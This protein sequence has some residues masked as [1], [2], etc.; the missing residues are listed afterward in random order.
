VGGTTGPALAIKRA[1]DPPDP[2]D[3]RRVL[4]DR[5]WPRGVARDRLQLDEWLKE[6]APSTA[7]RRWFGHD[8]AK[9]REFRRRYFVELDG[10]PEV[11]AALRAEMRQGPVTLVYSARD[12]EHNQALALRDYLLDGARADEPA[13]YASPP[14]FLHELDPAWTGLAPTPDP[15]QARDV[16]RWRKAERERLLADRRHLSVAERQR[17]AQAVA[18]HL[19][20]LLGEVAGLTISGWW[21]IKGELD[22]RPWLA[23]LVARGAVAALPVVAEKG[24]PLVFRRWSAGDRMVRGFWNIP[25]PAD[26][27]EVH[28]DVILAPVVGFD[29][30]AFR[31]GYGGG[32]F[33]RTLAALVPRPRAIG[34]GLE[35]ARIPTIYPQ[36]HDIPMTAIVTEAGTLVPGGM[37]VAASG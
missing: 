1:Y 3:G 36:P 35:S 4:V 24:R 31:L 29:G 22:L 10:R 23:G 26:G 28:P 19:D 20:T 30:D 8:P 7:L 14:C 15:Q 12:A 25:V 6:A 34:I 9:W 17:L 37:S 11:V 13:D 21:P 5:I 32:Y 16:A 27:A 2:A 18:G 33:D